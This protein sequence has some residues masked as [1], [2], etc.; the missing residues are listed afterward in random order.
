[1]EVAPTVTQNQYG[2]SCHTR[3]PL[4]FPIYECPYQ[5][6][7]WLLV[8]LHSCSKKKKHDSKP[9]VHQWL[10]QQIS[11]LPIFKAFPH[12]P[13]LLFQIGKKKHGMESIPSN[14]QHHFTIGTRLTFYIQRMRLIGRGRLET[15][16]EGSIGCMSQFQRDESYKS[17]SSIQLSLGIDDH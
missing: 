9:T 3:F 1:M 13:C 16:D 11:W 12:V 15:G 7:N 10:F 5:K 17:E 2:Q 4:D 14:I 8:G 6:P